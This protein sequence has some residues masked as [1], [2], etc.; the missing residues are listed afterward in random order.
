[1]EG[2]TTFFTQGGKTYFR[3]E[4]YIGNAMHFTEYVVEDERALRDL[5]GDTPVKTLT[6]RFS[7]GNGV[8]A[9]LKEN[10]VAYKDIYKGFA[11]TSSDV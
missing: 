5:V 8:L 9:F 10:G 2:F 11:D 3:V 4:C 6:E 7:E 1:M